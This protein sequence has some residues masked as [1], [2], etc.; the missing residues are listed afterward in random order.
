MRAEATTLIHNKPNM[1][2]YSVCILALSL[3]EASHF[4]F[5]FVALCEVRQPLFG[6]DTAN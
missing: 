1:H 6:L 5:F 2:K 3:M 4:F